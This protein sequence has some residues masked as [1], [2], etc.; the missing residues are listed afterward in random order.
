MSMEIIVTQEAQH[1]R[2][3]IRGC[4]SAGQLSSLMQVLGL[5]SPDWPTD[6]VVFDLSGIETPLNAV[7]QSALREDAERFLPRMKLVTFRWRG[8][9]GGGVR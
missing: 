7:Q 3:L 8:D 5:D 4:P 6:A 1:T 2:V 9:F